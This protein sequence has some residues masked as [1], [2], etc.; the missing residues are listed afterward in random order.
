MIGGEPGALFDAGA[1]RGVV[2]RFGRFARRPD[3]QPAAFLPVV[4]QQE[5]LAQQVRVGAA[6]AE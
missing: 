2:R 1:P 3:V 4:G 6:S 5:M